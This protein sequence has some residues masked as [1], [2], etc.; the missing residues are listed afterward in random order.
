MNGH[1]LR[2]GTGAVNIEFPNKGVLNIDWRILF[3]INTNAYDYTF[4]PD[5]EKLK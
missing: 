5:N 2:I 1:Q 4:Y 3:E